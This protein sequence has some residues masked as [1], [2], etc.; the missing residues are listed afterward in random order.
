M[1]IHGSSR[2]ATNEN[3]TMALVSAGMGEAV[4]GFGDG[5]EVV[6][7]VQDGGVF[8]ELKEEISVAKGIRI[9]RDAQ[10]KNGALEPP[11][12]K[13]LGGIMDSDSLPKDATVEHGPTIYTQ[14]VSRA[15]PALLANG[16]ACREKVVLNGSTE[17]GKLEEKAGE[18]AIKCNGDKGDGGI[19]NGINHAGN[20]G[21][22]DQLVE[23]VIQC[24]DEKVTL[25]LITLCA[26]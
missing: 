11:S 22:P 7:K 12:M 19:A 3:R 5:I 2:P 23:M 24:L 4:L 15:R 25:I 16:K 1:R 17:G 18:E 10:Q 21:S 6:N 14:F 20:S 26:P 13:R 9:D 8:A